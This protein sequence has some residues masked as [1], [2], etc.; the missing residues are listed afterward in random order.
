MKI[1]GYMQFVQKGELLLKQIEIEI[2][3]KFLMNREHSEA[4]FTDNGNQRGTKEAS[5]AMEKSLN[6][7]QPFTEFDKLASDRS[8]RSIK[9]RNGPV[10]R[11]N[12]YF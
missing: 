4:I 10:W 1:T 3:S 2:Q 7:F 9:D 5:T 6:H 11:L 8:L 12:G